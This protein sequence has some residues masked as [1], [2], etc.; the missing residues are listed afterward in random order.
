MIA[1]ARDLPRWPRPATI[2]AP[3]RSGAAASRP[4]HD[5]ATTGSG[6]TH[7]AVIFKRALVVLLLIAAVL[8]IGTSL[9][10][11]DEYLPE[12]LYRGALTEAWM[13]DAPVWPSRMPQ[14]AHIR[15]SIV[16]S[17]ISLPCFELL[18]P[19]TF[20]VRISGILFHLAGLV[21][22]MLLVRRQFGRNAALI[23]GAMFTLAPPALAKIAVLSYGDHIESLP[24]LFSAALA[25]LAW[26]EDRSGRRTGL[27]FAAG[28]LVGLAFSW[29]AQARLGVLVL[30]LF[31][32]AMAPRKLLQRDTWLGLAPGLLVGL[33]PHALGDWLLAQNGL[34]VFGSS[35]LDLLTTGDLSSRL[36]KWRA[37][38][39][40]DLP[41]SFQ[42]P[43]AST[44][45]FLLLLSAAC[46]A[47]L[48]WR[49]IGA[50]R[51]REVTL[52]ALV[53]RCGFFVAYP[54]AF[55]LAYALSEFQVQ[56]ADSAVMV[57]YVLP[58]IPVLLLPIPIAAARLWDEHRRALAG[59]VCGPAL[60][61]GL[62][63]SLST[64]D[65]DTILHEPAR[66]ATPYE[67][68]VSH[69]LYGSLTEDEQ[70]E[71]RALELSLYGTPQQK[72]VVN[73]WVGRHA[74][75]HRYLELVRRFDHLPTW[76][77]PL[78][79]E[80]PD[81]GDW[82]RVALP[83]PQWVAQYRAAPRYLR[84]Y[85]G[86]EAA[87]A[88][89]QARKFDPVRTA[90]AMQAGE[91]AEESQVLWRGLGQ[92]L[93]RYSGLPSLFDGQTAWR[94]VNTLPASVDRR[95]VAFGL[96]LVAGTLASE[97]YTP[98]QGIAGN[99]LMEEVLLHFPVALHPAFVR[100]LGA[101]YRWRFLDPP[102]S[103]LASPAVLRLV[104]RLP[105][106]LERDFRAGLGGS[107]AAFDDAPLAGPSAQPD[108]LR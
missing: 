11:V 81:S 94:R 62:W 104:A 47:W 32:A 38:W 23:A 70:R 50:V 73:S 3:L 40:R 82:P 106:G 24:F 13:R 87:R 90:A 101:G 88:L 51:R 83:A 67:A 74:D 85:I 14:I 34:K 76:T 4:L 31:C 45:V 95:E 91:S 107:S 65:L 89:G 56:R 36:L 49:S 1:A 105:P 37:F 7:G 61:L 55:S 77:L 44:G 21:A 17:A 15:G 10:R 96:G 108:A 69:F 99:Q 72:T 53:L 8:R 80:L 18:G 46:G 20:A 19:T 86:G 39:V 100:G 6:P 16:M 35:P 63:G 54:L 2:R 71:L 42:F 29:H 12:G 58:V 102:P 78:R 79:Y 52:H 84:P 9:S 25:M 66:R 93:G 68:Y 64:W 98:A 28:A 97:F 41:F 5:H 75:V 27:A 57:R 60:A 59:V 33:I 22:L 30:C 26:T 43:S 103:D 92:G 48:L